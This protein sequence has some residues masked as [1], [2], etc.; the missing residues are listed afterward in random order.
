MAWFATYVKQGDDNV[1]LEH[2]CGRWQIKPVG[3][4]GKA[5]A[6]A[7]V[8]A[9]KAPPEQMKPEGDKEKD[10]AWAWI[11]ASKEPC[12]EKCDHC[13]RRCSCG[14]EWYVLDVSAKWNKCPGVSVF[15]ERKVRLGNNVCNDSNRLNL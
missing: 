10:N 5:K 1:W 2:F 7:W 9:S 12:C 6:W 3:D 15:A 11:K 13:S 14:F 8:K 4:K